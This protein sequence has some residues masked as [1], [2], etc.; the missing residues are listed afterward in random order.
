VSRNDPK[1]RGALPIRRQRRQ[2]AVLCHNP[3]GNRDI[4]R[5]A[6]RVRCADSLVAA[7]KEIAMKKLRQSKQAFTLVE[8][9]VVIGLIA[10]LIAILLPALN[11]ARKAA[12]RAQCQSNVRQIYFGLNAY[13]DANHDWYPTCAYPTVVPSYVQYPD[14]WVWWEQ[15]RNLDDSPFA[16]SLSFRGEG[17]KRLLTCPGDVT[18]A[19]RLFTAIAPGQGPYPYSYT[20]N[21][22]IGVNSSPAPSHWRSRRSQWH[23]PAEKILATEWLSPNC[24]VWNYTVPLTRRHGQ[25]ISS[26]T[27]AAMGVNATTVF[28]DGHVT[29]VDED[30]SNDNSQIHLDR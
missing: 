16:K 29:G 21:V 24:G 2:Q 3:G 14:D 22:S 5:I 18:E 23:R 4:Q 26:K 27:G 25:G 19:R 13:C 7:S 11:K 12:Q 20:V 15:D 30:F 17:L 10:L 6:L 9:L 28:M 8:L 1:A